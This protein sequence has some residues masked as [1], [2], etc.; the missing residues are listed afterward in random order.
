MKFTIDWL[1]QYVDIKELS[2]EALAD[3]LTMLGLEV[4]S[5]TPIFPELASLRTAKV[6]SVE[7]HP[8]ADKLH[9]CEVA[10]GDET[11]SIVCGAPN[12]RK[13][14]VTTIALVGTVM[15]DGTKIKASKVRGVKSFGMLCSERELGLSESHTGIMELPAEF[16]HG[17]PLLEALGLDDL[18]VEVDLTPNRP[19]CASVIGIAREVSGIT[20]TPLTLPVESA[21]LELSRR[22]FSVDIEDSE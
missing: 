8:N 5:V 2:P 1:K 7:A 18:L 6:L 17:I 22:D 14:L 21:L 13:D 20:R 3:H 9:L 12:V 11:L 16:E 19:D 4:D 10:V 15:P